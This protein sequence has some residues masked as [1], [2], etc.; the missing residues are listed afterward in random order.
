MKTIFLYITL[1]L[2]AFLQA[3]QSGPTEGPIKSPDYRLWIYDNAGE[4]IGQGLYRSH[5]DASLLIYDTQKL[6][7]RKWHNLE[8]K[9]IPLNQIGYIEYRA[10]DEMEKSGK[11][12][13][14]VA[15]LVGVISSAAFVTV[16][17]LPINEAQASWLVPGLYVAAIGTVT[18]ALPIT[19][20]IYFYKL[21]A[22][23]FRQKI[24][25]KA[26]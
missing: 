19:L 4:L 23:K 2:P 24:H 21:N 11:R 6:S 8:Q 17:L 12:G 18:V 5:T 1:L 3:A 13:A 16:G 9:E 14:R 15:F 20:A 22:R 25:K 7:N 10:L 26:G